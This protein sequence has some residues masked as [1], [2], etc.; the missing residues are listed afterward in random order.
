MGPRSHKVRGA[1]GSRTGPSAASP[2]SPP[3]EVSVCPARL[4]MPP[5]SQ[6]LVHPLTL[7]LI[8]GICGQPGRGQAL[9]LA[10][11][12]GPSLGAGALPP[13]LPSALQ[14]CSAPSLQE[15]AAPRDSPPLLI[16]APFSH[17]PWPG[18]PQPIRQRPTGLLP[19]VL[20]MLQATRS[21][22]NQ[23][24]PT[25]PRSQLTATGNGRWDRG[26]PRT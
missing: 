25:L 10:V 14:E 6:H 12:A 11:W 20:A 2:A 5:P 15:E 18:L 13:N 1:A 4:R 19:R 26:S 16:P 22:T 23:E 17:P 21:H 3:G 7:A 9:P 24:P 8:L